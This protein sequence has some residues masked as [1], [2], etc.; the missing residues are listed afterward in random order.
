MLNM[1]KNIPQEVL[2]Q[3][4]TPLQYQVARQNATEPAFKNEY[5]DNKE[6]GL[7]VDI[8]SGDPLFSST[9]KFDSGTGWPSFICTIHPDTISERTDTSLGIE[10][11]EVRSLEADSHLGHVFE[12]GPGPD[13]TRYCINSASL[14]FIP[15]E[16]MIEQGYSDYLYLFPDYI[17]AQ[18]WQFATFAAGCFWGTEAYFSK[19][20]GVISVIT[21]YTGGTKANPVYEEVLKGE[22]GHLE[23]IMLVYDP[24]KISYETLLKHFWRIHDPTLVNRQGNDRGTE[25]QA[26]IFYHSP[27]QKLAAE[28]SKTA[29][30]RKKVYRRP[31][32]TQ[33]REASV[34]YPAELYHQDY[35]QKN[36]GG[37]CHIDLGLLNKPLEE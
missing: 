31:I 21:G 36:P 16:Q 6:P 34:F 1:E 15:V 19:L 26:A 2:R 17:K 22:T 13:G 32:A 28:S 10:R 3:K 29:L 11:T 23:S 8:I 5:W 37:Y 27:E 7:Y 30:T 14:K 18:G 25:Y 9:H 24:Q 33:I 35:L 20:S 12:D 4:L